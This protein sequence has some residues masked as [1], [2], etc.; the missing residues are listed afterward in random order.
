MFISVDVVAV[1]EK[2]LWQVGLCWV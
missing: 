1:Y 2:I